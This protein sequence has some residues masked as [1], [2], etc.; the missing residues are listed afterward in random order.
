MPDFIDFTPNLESQNC[1][2]RFCCWPCQCGLAFSN[3]MI[4]CDMNGICNIIWCCPCRVICGWCPTQ[5]ELEEPKEYQ[6]IMHKRR[7]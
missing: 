4:N 5:N 6:Y 1:C 3:A 7:Y 2:V